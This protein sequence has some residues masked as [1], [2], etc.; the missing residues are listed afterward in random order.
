MMKH[1]IYCA[2]LLFAFSI[3]AK[4]QPGAIYSK[5]EKAAN[6]HHVGSVWL[7]E[8]SEADSTFDYTTAVAIFDANARLDWHKHPGGQILM[9]IEGTGY[10]QERGKPRQTIN[11]GDVI[12]CLPDVEYWH[13]ATPITSVTYIATSP[14]AKGRTVWL[15]RV[16]EE[17]YKKN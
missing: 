8:L 17:E 1:L 9:I 6:V 7:K 11:K 4:G 14:V 12:K 2:F 13:G 10:Y 5:G 3:G 16:T 15:D